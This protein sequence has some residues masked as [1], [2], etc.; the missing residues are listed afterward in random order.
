M[1]W[2]L[3]E[4]ARSE[5]PGVRG[6]GLARDVLR[7]GVRGVAVTDGDG[8]GGGG[9][10]VLVGLAGGG[11]GDGVLGR[12]EDMLAVL[13]LKMDTVNLQCVNS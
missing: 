11:G 1:A 10:G 7:P 5:P 13:A 3:D 8:D 12:G 4:Q 2:G 6:A 9:I